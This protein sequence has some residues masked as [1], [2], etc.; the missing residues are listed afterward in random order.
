MIEQLD[1]VNIVVADMAAMIAFY[2]DVF[3]L[4]LTKQATIRGEWISAVTGLDN[5]VADVAFL[6]LPTGPSIELLHYQSPA[7][8]MAGPTPP[9][10]GGIR[11][12]AFR[13]TDIDRLVEAMEARGVK[14]F[15]PVAQV[16]AAQVDYAQVRKRLIYC[17]DPEGNLL[18]LCEYA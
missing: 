3:G 8:T 6:E 10:A 11:H 13:V 5:V 1:H 14:F 7:S 16:P 15:S 9:N 12:L 4:R 18:E 17:R 2:R